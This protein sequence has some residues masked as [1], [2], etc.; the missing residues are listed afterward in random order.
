MLTV[1]FSAVV[2]F[3]L[4]SAAAGYALGPVDRLVTRWFARAKDPTPDK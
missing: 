3:V 4:L 1:I 2:L